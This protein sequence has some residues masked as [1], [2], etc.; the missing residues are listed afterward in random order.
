V[1]GRSTRAAVRLAGI[2]LVV[3]AAVSA[4]AAALPA[5]RDASVLEAKTHAAL[6]DLYA[7]DTRL[8]NA[9]ARLA[10]LQSQVEQLRKQ[11]T[12]LAQQ[13]SATRRTLQTSQR[14]LAE[15]LRT[16]YEQGEVDP[17]AV[18]LGAQSLDDAMTKLDDL[19]RVADQ[20]RQFV[21][22]TSA[23]QS[24]LGRLRAS[25]ADRRARVNVSITSA[26]RTADDLAA[27]HAE[28]VA[29]IGA[30]QLKAR[31]LTALQAAAQRVEAKSQKL[32]AAASVLPPNPATSDVPST[33][34]AA[35]FADAPAAAPVSGGRTITVSSTGYSLPG[36][37]AT[38]MPVG[39]GV[40]AVDPSLIPLGTRMTI[41]GYGEGVAA[42]TGGAVRGTSIDLWFPTHA[43][44]L[45][46]GRRTVTITL[47]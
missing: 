47:H 12:Q 29:F 33:P 15:N 42:D 37:T 35:T 44:A 31:Q 25:L 18:V 6:L 17:L 3:L 21:V 2:S 41:P 40:V 5:S 39:W 26:R 23:A 27:A 7:L 10:T 4:A 16:L 22:V 8:H 38:G 43:Q 13:L 36:R 11:Q 30:L 45:G 9:Q 46:W 32:Q 34:T 20:S 28:R 1:G 14:R 19:T 24:R